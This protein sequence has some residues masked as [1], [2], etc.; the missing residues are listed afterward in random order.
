MKAGF[1]QAGRHQGGGRERGR[2]ADGHHAALRRPPRGRAARPQGGEERRQPAAGRS[3]GA[4]GRTRRSAPTPREAVLRW[5][6]YG[7]FDAVGIEVRDG[8]RQAARLGREPLEARRDRGAAR[9]RRRHPRRASTTCASRASR[10]GDVRCAARS[11]AKSTPTRCSSAGPT[12]PDPPV[13]VFVDAGAGHPRRHGR[14]RRSSRSRR[15]CIARGTLAFSVNNQVKVESERRAQR[16]PQEGT[17][18]ELGGGRPPARLARGRGRRRTRRRP[19]AEHARGPRCRPGAGVTWISCH[20]VVA[21]V[22]IPS[23][24][25]KPSTVMKKPL[26]RP[27][28]AEHGHE[29]AGPLGAALGGLLAACRPAGC[30]CGRRTSRSSSRGRARRGS[31]PR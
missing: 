26:K 12:M 2:A 19:T 27:Q 28:R 31:A 18:R 1:E 23:S 9:P 6:R 3:R 10:Q 13:R 7:P 29:V 21:S 17:D 8:R 22:V 25:M 11:H 20:F 24:V 15:A 5:E 14:Q 30:G 16:R 4:R